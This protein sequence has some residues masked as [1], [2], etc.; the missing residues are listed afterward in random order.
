MICYSKMCNAFSAAN[1]AISSIVLYACPLTNVCVW[2]SI[3]NFIILSPLNIF[4]YFSNQS[5][6]ISSY[7]S[8][9]NHFKSTVQ[10]SLCGFVC[11]S[12]NLTILPLSGVKCVC[13]A[14]TAAIICSFSSFFPNV[15]CGNQLYGL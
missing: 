15:I 5:L 10:I 2:V 11:A 14:L 6:H 3:V 7:L 1:A 12:P 9:I 13:I 4:I 8:T